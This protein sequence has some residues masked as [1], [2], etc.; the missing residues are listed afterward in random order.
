MVVGPLDRHGGE[1]R[2]DLLAAVADERGGVAFAAG[3]PGPL[4]APTVG[5]Q[6]LLQHP[7][8]DPVHDGAGG[9][10]GGLQ[11]QVASLLDLAQHAGDQAVEF[12]GH[13]PL[14]RLRNFFSSC[15][16]SRPSP[17]TRTGRR[18]H[19]RSFTSTSSAHRRTKVR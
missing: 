3:N 19:S 12:L 10:F 4:M 5:V 18:S 11:V 8:P 16:R 13:F 14:K 17:T 15:A 2:A 6:E 9:Q 7:P 1:H